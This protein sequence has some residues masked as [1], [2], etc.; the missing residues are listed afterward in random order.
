MQEIKIE[1]YEV[2]ADTLPQIFDG[3]KIAYLV[4][5][6][7]EAMEESIRKLFYQVK[8]EK[9]DYVFLGGD[10][11]VGKR[12]FTLEKAEGVL[13][14]VKW[15]TSYFPV[16]M[17]MGNHEQKLSAIEETKDSTYLEYLSKLK[18]L[19]VTILD[20]DVVFLQKGGEKIALYG[21]TA[22]YYYYGKWWKFPKMKPEYLVENLGEKPSGLFSILLCHTPKYFK[23]YAAWG[24][25]L[26]LSGHIHGGIM[27]LPGLGGVIAP[28][29]QLFP[30]YDRGLFK[31]GKHSMVLSRGLG[32]HTIKLRI[33]NPPELS[34]ITLKKTC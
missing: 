25:D 15:L 27:I 14:L 12:N 18:Q 22:D 4:D 11:I 7:S 26:T 6:H 17:G 24:A 20:N 29:Y 32:S 9:P 31:E 28:D 19:G 33:F 10:M 21:L 16:Y 34:I 3:A 30:K 1:H 5:I 23:S 2:Q 13:K 8:K